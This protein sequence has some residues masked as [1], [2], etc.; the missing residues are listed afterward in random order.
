MLNETVLALISRLVTHCFV[1]VTRTAVPVSAQVATEFESPPILRAKSFAPATPRDG[2]GMHASDEVPTDGLTANL[3]IYSDPGMVQAHGLEMLKIGIAEVPAMTKLQ[4]SS[5]TKVFA[6][7]LATIAVRPVKM[8][9][10]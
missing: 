6:R 2:G 4:E 7:S 10:Y 1:F 5:K 8:T 3:T 9:D